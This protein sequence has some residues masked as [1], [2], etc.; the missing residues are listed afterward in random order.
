LAR[1]PRHSIWP[2]RDQRTW[3]LTQEQDYQVPLA[4][5]RIPGLKE[6]NRLPRFLTDQQVR[7][8]RD[9][10]EERLARARSASKR[11]DALLERAAFYLL[12]QGGLRLGEVEELRLAD[13]NLD[14]RK[15]TVRQGKGCKD[16]TVYLTGTVIQALQDYLAVRGMGP[17]DHVF[18]YRN[19]P[20]C[21]DLVRDRIQAAGVQAGVKVSPH[22]L[23]HTFATQLLNAGCRVTTIQKLLGHRRLNSTLIYARVHD[24]IVAEDYYAAMAKIEQGLDQ[25]ARTDEASQP[26]NPGERA[27]L[28][29][30]VQ[31]LA[32][33]DLDQE[34]R[35]DLLA[36]MRRVLHCE[37]PGQVEAPTNGKGP[38]RAL[39]SVA[40]L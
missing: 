19:R 37:T 36:Q 39:A 23:R 32:Q 33:P 21:K 34:A 1:F 17:S 29:E 40:Q 25:P 9:E 13:L 26:L 38:Q 18:L 8:L 15:L 27:R 22:R 20:L 10:I 12:W 5:L 28:L 3:P 6:P 30:L 31:R 24:R 16:R 11:R 35:L 4:L 7:S 14:G 2:C